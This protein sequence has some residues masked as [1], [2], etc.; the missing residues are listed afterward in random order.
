MATRATAGH[1]GEHV[2]NTPGSGPGAEGLPT[3]EVVRT[4]DSAD[5]YKWLTSITSPPLSMRVETVKAFLNANID[6][7]TFLDL[8]DKWYAGGAQPVPF[9]VAM[10]L[11]QLATSIKLHAPVLAASSRKR[12]MPSSPTGGPDLRGKKQRVAKAEDSYTEISVSPV[13][14]ERF[15]TEGSSWSVERLA[16]A[17]YHDVVHK[18]ASMSIR[19]LGK[20][21]VL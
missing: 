6:G 13:P 3:E 10:R 1:T 17:G 14:G 18:L 12:A 15:T 21:F 2:R 19:S 11:N 4:W 20:S 9:G 16:A 7:S 8:G 5:L